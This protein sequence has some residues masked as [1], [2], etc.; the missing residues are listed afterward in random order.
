MHVSVIS[1]ITGLLFGFMWA[2]PVFFNN[3]LEK[4]KPVSRQVAFHLSGIVVNLLLALVLA[5][6]RVIMSRLF[7]GNSVEFEGGAVYPST[8]TMFLYSQLSCLISANL[9]VACIALLPLPGLD[10]FNLL[11]VFAESKGVVIRR[12][13]LYIIKAITLSIFFL[14]LLCSLLQYRYPLYE[15]YHAFHYALFGEDV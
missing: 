14:Y 12:E 6:F 1:M 15:Q 13:V 4:N 11:W 9:F 5:F 2:K 3:R 8:A 10:G 7:G